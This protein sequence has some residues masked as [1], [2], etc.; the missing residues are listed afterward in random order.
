MTKVN[1]IWV[2]DN[3]DINEV[4]NPGKPVTAPKYTGRNFDYIDKAYRGFYRQPVGIGR[5]T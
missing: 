3:S 2:K 4:K 5:L 1:G